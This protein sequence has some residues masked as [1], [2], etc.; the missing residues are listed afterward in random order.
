LGDPL[1]AKKSAA[2]PLPA[3]LARSRP[4]LQPPFIG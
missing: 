4:L 1:R 3:R 2:Y